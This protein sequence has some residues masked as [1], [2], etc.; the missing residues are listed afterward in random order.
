MACALF[1][2]RLPRF[3]VSGIRPVYSVRDVP[4]L[5]QQVPSPLPVDGDYILD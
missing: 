4:G 5:Y 3:A 1:Y 2:S